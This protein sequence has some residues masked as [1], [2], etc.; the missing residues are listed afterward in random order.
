V[1]PTFQPLL[2]DLE[3]TGVVLTADALQT[4]RDAA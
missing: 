4:Y 3:S 1:V 2:A